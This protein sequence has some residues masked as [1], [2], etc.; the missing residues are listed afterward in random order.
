MKSLIV[1]SAGFFSVWGLLAGC[2]RSLRVQ[3]HGGGV[4]VTLEFH[5]DETVLDMIS[6]TQRVE[7]SQELIDGLEAMEGVAYKVV[8]G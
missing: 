5:H 6:R 8:G 7:L 1:H 4:G 2:A 3:S